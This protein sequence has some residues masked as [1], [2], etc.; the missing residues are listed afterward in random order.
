[1]DDERIPIISDIVLTLDQQKEKY[2]GHCVPQKPRLPFK[3]FK[4]GNFINRKFT[5]ITFLIPSVGL[6]PER[7]QQIGIAHNVH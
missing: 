1:M 7:Y 6:L 2:I 3:S 4:G 5:A